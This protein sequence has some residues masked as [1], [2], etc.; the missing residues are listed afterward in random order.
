MSKKKELVHTY[1]G[2]KR[3][4]VIAAFEAERVAMRA[5]GYVP[6]DERWSEPGVDLTAERFGTYSTGKAPI[7][8][9]SRAGSA[10]VAVAL[11]HFQPEAHTYQLE[12]RYAPVE[13]AAKSQGGLLDI[14]VTKNGRCPHCEGPTMQMP[15]P[16]F[17][18][19]CNACKAEFPA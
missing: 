16:P 7:G 3:D 1:A 9:G 6:V 10:L 19:Y 11:S 5:K 2:E 15:R 12:V 18:R 17:E 13:Q 8:I 4:E 14:T